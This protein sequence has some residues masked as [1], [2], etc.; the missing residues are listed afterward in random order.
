MQSSIKE[1][2][3]LKL[4]SDHDIIINDIKTNVRETKAIHEIHFDDDDIIEV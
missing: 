1:S 2:H 3:T 4:K